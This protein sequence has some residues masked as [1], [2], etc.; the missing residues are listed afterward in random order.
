MIGSVGRA[1]RGAQ[2]ASLLDGT[3][4][5]HHIYTLG[6]RPGLV[7]DREIARCLRHNREPIDLTAAAVLHRALTRSPEERSRSSPQPRGARGR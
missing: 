5:G 3:L 4:L 1:L 2:A 7:N 6:P